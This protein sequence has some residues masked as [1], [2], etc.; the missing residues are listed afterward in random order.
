MLSTHQIT[1]ELETLL[2]IQIQQYDNLPPHREPND[3]KILLSTLVDDIKAVN[4][5]HNLTNL[6][7]L[8][9]SIGEYVNACHV[10]L[11]HSDTYNQMTIEEKKLLKIDAYGESVI[12]SA[13]TLLAML[14]KKRAKENRSQLKTNAPESNQNTTTHSIP[15]TPKPCLYEEKKSNDKPASI[16]TI[17]YLAQPISSLGPIKLT[18]HASVPTVF[19]AASIKDHSLSLKS[20]DKSPPKQVLT[21]KNHVKIR[22]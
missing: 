8:E 22:I 7:K 13:L 16:N 20:E 18:S 10:D 17:K 21:K 3:K 5:Q 19:N 11:I 14:E 15:S 4:N 9:F 2:H 1:T 12:Q 6:R